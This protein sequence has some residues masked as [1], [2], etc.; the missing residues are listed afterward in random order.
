[1][2]GYGATRL[3]LTVRADRRIARRHHEANGYVP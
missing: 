2:D 1:M 3:D